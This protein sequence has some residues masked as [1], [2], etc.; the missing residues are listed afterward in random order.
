MQN[1]QSRQCNLAVTGKPGA[2][3]R[4]MQPVSANHGAMYENKP[5]AKVPSN[6]SSGALEKQPGLRKVPEWVII[7]LNPGI[8][9]AICNQHSAWSSVHGRGLL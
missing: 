9:N 3:S 8:H 6:R 1:I 4:G 2:S 7:T 5:R